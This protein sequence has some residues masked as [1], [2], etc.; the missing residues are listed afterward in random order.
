MT[1]RVG[2]HE[3]RANKRDKPLSTTE[4]KSVRAHE[5]PVIHPER[6]SADQVVQAAARMRS[7]KMVPQST[8]SECWALGLTT[9]GSPDLML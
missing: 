1:A 4:A 5:L 8:G 7:L 2:F 6:V 9:T 3:K